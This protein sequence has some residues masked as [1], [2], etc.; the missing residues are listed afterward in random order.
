MI[1]AFNAIRLTRNSLH[2]GGVY[3]FS[4]TKKYKLYDEMYTFECGKEVKPIRLIIIIKLIWGHYLRIIHT[5]KFY[6]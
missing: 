5:N 1:D 2:Q 4:E 3:K 6:L